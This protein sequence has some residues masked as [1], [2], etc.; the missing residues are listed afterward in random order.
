MKHSPVGEVFTTGHG[1][2]Q[3]SKVFGVFSIIDVYLALHWLCYLHTDF[4][5]QH[6]INVVLVV[7]CTHLFTLHNKCAGKNHCSLLAADVVLFFFPRLLQPR[8]GG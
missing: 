1:V 2:L 7:K 8:A 3:L 5:Y 4:N 6:G